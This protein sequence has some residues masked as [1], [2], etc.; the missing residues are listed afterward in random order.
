LETV[1]APRDGADAGAM[2]VALVQLAEQDPLIDLRQDDARGETY[3]SLYG[4]VQ[5]EVIEQTLADDF[6]V[7][8]TFRETTPICIERVVGTGE[9]AER[10]GE[11]HNPFLASIGLRVEPAA[12]GSGVHLDV[13]VKIETIPR[14]VYKSVEL[15]RRAMEKYACDALRQGLR[16]WH[17]PDCVVTVIE[18]DYSSP[19]SLAADF[20]QL[21]P[22]VLLRALKHAGT[23]V[24]EP[25][26]R[27]RLD[28]PADALGAALRAIVAARGVPDPPVLDG[29]TETMATIE[30]VIPAARVHAL[31]Q[32]IPGMS[33]GEGVVESAFDSYQPTTG[34]VP[35][36]PRTDHNPL[37]RREYLASVR[38]S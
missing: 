37:D 8:V 5:K 10:M 7:A 34:P 28:V 36:R 3:V 16:G 24:C 11:H 25:V 33:R 35:S 17:V 29:S 20:R 27:F 18:S 19:G 13:D 4:E 21:M 1:I 31:Q 6:G 14:F 22:L 2:H 12:P 32:Q 26:H 15:Y 30:G 9:A 38:R 23:V